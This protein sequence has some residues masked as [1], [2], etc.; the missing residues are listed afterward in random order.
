MEVSGEEREGGVR[1]FGKFRECGDLEIFGDFGAVGCVGIFLHV[2]G[3]GNRCPKE[4]SFER[5]VVA[6]SE[7]DGCWQEG[8]VGE[9]GWRRDETGLERMCVEGA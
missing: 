5:R 4:S 1:R 6:E 7:R 3:V 2:T 8:V 9:G